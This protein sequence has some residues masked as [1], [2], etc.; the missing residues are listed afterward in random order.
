MSDNMIS[1]EKTKD[2]RVVETTERLKEKL[3]LPIVKLSICAGLH[4]MRPFDEWINHDGLPNEHVD[5]VSEFGDIPLPNECVDI[6]ECGDCIEHVVKWRK[7]EVLKEWFRLLKVGGKIHV[8]TPNFHS[9]MIDYA[10]RTLFNDELP[11]GEIQLTASSDNGVVKTSKYRLPPPSGMPPIVHATQ[12]IYAWQSTAYEQHYDLYS[13]ETL[14][15]TMEQYGFGD[16]DFSDS[17]PQEQ[18]NPR[19]SWW[20]SLTAT[21]LRNV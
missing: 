7:D 5:L 14:K 20:L 17:P 16:I 15:E 4:W 10:V 11:S 18:N 21:K 19:D 12:R 6:L 3:S 8:Q 13:M 2:E 1:L 9:A